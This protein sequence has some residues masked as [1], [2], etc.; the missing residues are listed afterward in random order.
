MASIYSYIGRQTSCC[1]RKGKIYVLYIE[2]KSVRGEDKNLC[3]VCTMQ[4][5]ESCYEYTKLG[6]RVE[7]KENGKR[8]V[9]VLEK[10]RKKFVLIREK[11]EKL[12][13][14]TMKTRFQHK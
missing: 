4:K 5:V 13:I 7:K 8:K 2:E 14:C 10:K 3:L 9:Y 1:S 6:G 12:C 11:H